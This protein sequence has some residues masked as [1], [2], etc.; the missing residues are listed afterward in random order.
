MLALTQ[1]IFGG[2]IPDVG[3]R[4]PEPMATSSS[5]S[6]LG[7]ERLASLFAAEALTMLAP[8]SYERGS[9]AS[10]SSPVLGFRAHARAR[11]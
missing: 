3:G 5:L 10:I 1:R 2:E 9:V 6:C 11:R 4:E 8:D 7:M